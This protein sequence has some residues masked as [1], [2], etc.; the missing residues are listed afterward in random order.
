[1]KEIFDKYKTEIQ[2]ESIKFNKN[3]KEVMKSLIIM[4]LTDDRIFKIN[5]N[6]EITSKMIFKKL[7]AHMAGGEIN[8]VLFND[9]NPYTTKKKDQLTN[10]FFALLELFDNFGKDTILNNY[11]ISDWYIIISILH[12]KSLG[13]KEQIQQIYSTMKSV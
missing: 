13:L 6:Y 2:E 1:M 5:N 7:L 11:S 8:L 12:N 10:V 3:A 9:M 4:F